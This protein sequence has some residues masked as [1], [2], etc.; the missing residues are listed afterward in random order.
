RKPTP[1]IALTS[2]PTPVSP[3]ESAVLP[4][5]PLSLRPA[6]PAQSCE[7]RL[8]AA[9][10]ELA[11]LKSAV[12]TRDAST[13]SL[14]QFQ[15]GESNPALEK[16]LEPD[17]AR[18][19]KTDENKREY[20]LECRGRI[21]RLELLTSENDRDWQMALQQDLRKHIAGVMFAGRTPTTD[22]VTK[23]ALFKSEV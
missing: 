17:L 15:N 20:T 21:C 19:L 13:L 4:P 8:T 1:T 14:Q 18:A 16:H 12:A 3:P 9:E 2:V 11:E 23:E 6:A 10:R 7:E 5:E 22:P